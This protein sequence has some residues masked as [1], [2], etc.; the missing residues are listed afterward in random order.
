LDAAEKIA[1][2]EAAMTKR[3]L[4][5]HPVG[6]VMGSKYELMLQGGAFNGG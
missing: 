6:S 4:N 2:R 3:I 5:G 1:G